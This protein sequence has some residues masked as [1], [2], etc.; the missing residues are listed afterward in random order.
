MFRSS[1]MTAALLVGSQSALAQPPIDA[2]SQLR[3]IPPQPVPPPNAPV[4]EVAPRQQATLPDET[5]PSVRVTRLTVTGET[6]FSEAELIAASGFTPGAELNLGQMRAVAARITAFYNARGYFLAQAYLPPQ[7]VSAGAVTIAVIEGR[8]GAVGI[9]NSSHVSGG[10]ARRLLRGLD[11]GDIVASAPLE[12]RLLLLSDIPGMAVR[13]TLAPG[14]E[15]GTSDLNVALTPGRRFTGSI[16]ADNGGNRY[17]GAY[18]LGGTINLNNPLGIGDRLSL[19]VLGST[20]GL[21]YG[22]A[23]YQL[24]L[25][26]LTVG[27]SFS[28]IRYELGREFQG[29]D[30]DGTADVASLY[31]SYPLVRSRDSNLYLLAGADMSWFQDRIGLLDSVSDRASRTVNIGLGGDSHDRFGGGGWSSY[32]LSAT[33]GTLDIRTPLDLANDALTARS[34]GGFGKIEYNV[35]RLQS[36]AGPLSL[37]ASLRGQIAFANLDSSEKMELG[38]AYG[39]RAYPEGEAFGD[40]GYIATA[41]ARL[42]LNRWTR[43]LPGQFQLIAFIDTGSVDYAH[44]PWF[45][46]RN[47]SNRSGFGGGLNWA[48][49][50]DL[51]VRATYARRLGDEATSAPDG[52]GRAWFQIVKLF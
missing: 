20:S 16:E 48:G 23:A 33:F 21:A 7:D 37:Y 24:P 11:S 14:S 10:V 51:V 46:G 17:T 50:H 42:A 5:G 13:S 40:E 39:V 44:E 36:L 22:R 35:A 41:E 26:A 52:G 43:G 2:G 18:R 19:R 47:R 34:D 6:L 25:G 29:L 27:A 1:M 3:Q 49:P 38:G 9:H 4:L 31:A 15:V 28:H 8:Y 12:R 45:P 30:A 32:S